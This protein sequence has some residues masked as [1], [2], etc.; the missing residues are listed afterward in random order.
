VA[1]G[2]EVPAERYIRIMWRRHELCRAARQRLRGLDGVVGPTLPMAA[3]PRKNFD[4]ADFEHEYHR[5]VPWNTRPGNVLGLCAT[6]TPVRVYGA[7]LPVGLQVLCQGY[8]EDRVLAVARTIE[9]IV[10]A[11]PR[12]DLTPFLD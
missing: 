6:T 11:P 2:L 1:H 4:D 12:P 5:I 8:C 7:A 9:E 10:G 3:V